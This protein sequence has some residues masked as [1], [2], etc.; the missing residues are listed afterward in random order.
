MSTYTTE[1]E[2]VPKALCHYGRAS[3]LCHQVTVLCGIQVS[4]SKEW[5]GCAGWSWA[6][7]GARVPLY[8]ENLPPW[9]Q[10]TRTD[11]IK[12][13]ARRGDLLILGDDAQTVL[14]A[15]KPWEI[16]NCLILLYR[17]L[18]GFLLDAPLFKERRLVDPLT[19]SASALLN[20]NRMKIGT[21]P[22]GLATQKSWFIWI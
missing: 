8:E 9:T 13:Q 6:T 1:D 14:R 7:S 16:V 15:W 2:H 5:G 3:W 18:A 19:V 20:S 12:W 10:T 22:L 4:P 21:C 17:P 11:R